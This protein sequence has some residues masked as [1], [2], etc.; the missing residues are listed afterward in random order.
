MMGHGY[1][2]QSTHSRLETLRDNLSV[3]KGANVQL[4]SFDFPPSGNRCKIV[5]MKTFAAA[6]FQK[7]Q[8]CKV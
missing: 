4:L 2:N 7:I 6:V 3:Y 5:P 8:V 1:R